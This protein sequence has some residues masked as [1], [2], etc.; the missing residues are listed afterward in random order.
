MEFNPYFTC[1]LGSVTHG[2]RH[3]NIIIPKSSLSDF[4][5]NCLYINLT[6]DQMYGKS[7]EI[8]IY[9][10]LYTQGWNNHSSDKPHISK[11]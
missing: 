10:S 4:T 6:N 3:I 8:M 2:N 5:I 7:A 1:M 11:E 9:S